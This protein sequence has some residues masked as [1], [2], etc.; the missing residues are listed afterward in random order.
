MFAAAA[1]D[2]P[3]LLALPASA[4]LLSLEWAT[5]LVFGGFPLEV[6]AW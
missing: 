4:G 1:A 3:A 6:T 5:A 2:G